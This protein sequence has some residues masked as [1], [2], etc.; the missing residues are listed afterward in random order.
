MPRSESKPVTPAVAADIIIELIDRPDHPIVLIERLNPPYGWAI[1][2]G[3]VDVG[4]TVEAAAIREAQEET[5]LTVTLTA[6]LGCY[7]SPERDVRGH[8]I[9]IVYVAQATGEP[10]AQDDA[11]DLVICQLDELPQPLVFD[12]ARIVADYRRLRLGERFSQINLG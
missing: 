3:F 4:E 7:S 6:L 8:T 11:K 5:G 2:G 10:R 9:S 12:H 1:P